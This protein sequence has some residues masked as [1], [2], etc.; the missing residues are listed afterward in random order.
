MEDRNLKEEF[1]VTGS[2][3]IEL[4]WLGA[5]YRTAMDS[6]T[7]AVHVVDANLQ[8]VLFNEA[9]KRW[10]QQMEL[11]TEVI[12]KNLFEVFPFL[13]E[14]VREEYQRIFD[15]GVT[16]TNED[17]V[18][19]A[20]RELF[21][22]VRRTPVFSGKKVT[23]VV[24]IVRNIT[25]RKRA[26][27][28]LRESEERFRTV[29]D[30][31]YDWEYWQGPDK[32]LIY[33]SP[34]CERITGYA[35]EEFIKN[36]N[37][38]LE[39]ILPED[40]KLVEEY[41][42]K[43]WFSKDATPIDFRIVHKDGQVRWIGHICQA[44]FDSTGKF[45]GRRGSNRDIT[46]RK[47][48]EE[49]LHNIA[50]FPAE[51][52]YPVMRIS[53][54]GILMYGNEASIPIVRLWDCKVGQRVP[55][56]WRQLING[57]LTDGRM[58]NDV[59]IEIKDRI[60]SF[61]IVPIIGGE[62]VNLYGLDVTKSKQA[63]A[64]L[65]G[66]ERFLSDIFNSI[67]DGISV[68]DKDLD[69]IRVNP[70]MEKW[71]AHALPLSGKKCYEAYH[72]K[73]EACKA[74]PSVRALE[75]GEAAYE[76]VPKRGLG[77]E[78]VGW[79]DL[80]A[81]PLY[82]AQNGQVKGVI[83]YVRDITE[84]K[85]VES[86]LQ[87]RIEL[88]RLI[89]KISA[90]FVN[91]SSDS[92]TTEIN[93]ALQLLGEFCQVDRSYVFEAYDNLSKADCTYEWYAPGIQPR[94][95]RLKG[96]TIK[97][98]AWFGER[99]KKLE[100]V[101]VPCFADL[102]L[103]AASEKQFFKSMGVKSLI[104]VPIVYAGTLTGFLGFDSEKAEKEWSEDTISL[105][106]IVGE[107]FANTL[108]RRR[109]R[110]E[111]EALQQ[112]LVKSNEKLKQLVLRDSHTGLYNHRYLTEIIE[113]EF[114]RARRSGNALSVIMLDIDYF[115]SIND[116]Y[117]HQF[118]DLVL[119]QF[120]TQLKRMVRQ[121]DIVVRFGGEEFVIVSPGTDKTTI[122]QLAQRLLDAI[123]LYNFGNEKHLVKLKLSLAIASYPEDRAI[124]GMDLI[125]LTD[126][127]L[128][129][130]KEYG[131]NRVY[132]YSDIKKESAPLLVK[133]GHRTE[134]KLLKNKIEK[135]TKRANQS[136]IEAVLAF[137]KTI[138]LKDHYT[139]EHVEKT[140]HFAREIAKVLNLTTDEVERI[141]QASIPHDLGKL[142]I[143]EK[144][145]LKKAALTKNEF[146]E[147]RKHPQIG[148]DI[149]RPIQFLHGIIPFLLYH[150]ERWDG[151]GYPHGLKGEEIPIGARIVAIA[152]VYQSLTSHRPYRK[153]YSKKEAIEIIKKGAGS[154][155][156][157]KVVDGFLRIIE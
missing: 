1:K 12:G 17:K 24:T 14:R 21:V 89:T 120:A 10:N 8:I 154:Q 79:L 31:T 25:E 137:A 145:L 56:N 124:K 151:K 140:V 102:P 125:E 83:E 105:L 61:T 20:G 39:I 77:G 43:I 40:R 129:K 55:E 67:Q 92:I 148:V 97:K 135:L 2:A 144:I 51:D 71:Y 88:E 76:L 121:Y 90:S 30:F 110:R 34:S 85:K 78:I 35:Q 156:D 141:G 44:V 80:F 119:K 136:L 111:R 139:G 23:R 22:D 52:P 84:R 65:V 107:I 142:G 81:F 7:D 117:G 26:E 29:S 4:G 134:V 62:Y 116:V 86:E 82:D 18:T 19:V 108:Q 104:V 101:H 75:T 126:Q 41:I 132:S 15:T 33:I 103:E 149:I 98:F 147:I 66:N 69:I 46:E 48:M 58:K 127:I 54:D 59:E 38:M 146:K 87:Y 153:A 123:N 113:V 63:A 50:K 115:K 152:D 47:Q 74:C 36:P 100:V 70:T 13:S 130:V 96:L 118:G 112:E 3:N 143:S 60:F 9:F 11:Q 155:F 131:G 133:N 53:K 91:F 28:M 32:E 27:E 64:L 114:D 99:I 128:N 106:K 45:M 6:I 73:S 5:E 150:H 37:L 138:E 122:L 109:V 42:E 72:S 57:V 16:L 94:I 93:K 68:L 49:E 157:P 95:G